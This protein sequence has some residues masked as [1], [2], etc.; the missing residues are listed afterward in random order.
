M[1]PTLT[2]EPISHPAKHAK[3]FIFLSGLDR[4]LHLSCVRRDP[5]A[6][7]SRRIK[8]LI[9][10]FALQEKMEIQMLSTNTILFS[11]LKQHPLKS[12]KVYIMLQKRA[13]HKTIVCV[14][15]ET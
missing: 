2:S 12:G 7:M 3:P 9:F 1:N 13:G 4:V 8:R 10:S 5:R 14:N 15:R 11:F 6:I